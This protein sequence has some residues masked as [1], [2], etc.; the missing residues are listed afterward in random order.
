MVARDSRAWRA[1]LDTSFD[2]VA[3]WCP[4]VEGVLLR[5]TVIPPQQIPKNPDPHPRGHDASRSRGNPTYR[6]TT[7]HHGHLDELPGGPGTEPQGILQILTI[8]PASLLLQRPLRPRD[9]RQTPR[10]H[11]LLGQ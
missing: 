9:R 11:L 7:H 10:T 4:G 5:R 3:A 8:S 6:R 2:T 1:L